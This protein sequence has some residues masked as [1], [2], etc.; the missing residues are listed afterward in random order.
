M[1]TN[2][3]GTIEK[4]EIFTFF[5]ELAKEDDVRDEERKKRQAAKYHENKTPVTIENNAPTEAEK[6]LHEEAEKA[7]TKLIEEIK[8]FKVED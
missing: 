5:K 2:K 4:S 1:D 3:N 8:S 6:K 7:K